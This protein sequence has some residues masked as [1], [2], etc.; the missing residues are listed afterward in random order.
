MLLSCR[1]LAFF[2]KP[3]KLLIERRLRLVI[4]VSTANIKEAKIKYVTSKLA[5][6]KEGM[7]GKV[8]SIN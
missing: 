4:H 3:V 7:N 8:Y 2:G 1:A 6:G 5:E